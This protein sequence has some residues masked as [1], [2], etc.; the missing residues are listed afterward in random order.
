LLGRRAE[1][2]GFEPLL[3]KRPEYVVMAICLGMQSLNVALGGNLIQ[4]I[5]SQVYRIKTLEQGIKA[6][7]DTI[8]R[9]FEAF[10][11]PGPGVGGAHMHGLRLV[12][13]SKFASAFR[14]FNGAKVVSVH[15]QGVAKV[16][17][18][19]KV[20]ATSLDGK[21][22]EGLYHTQY[23]NVFGVQFHPEKRHLWNHKA[24][25]R[26]RAGTRDD[27]HLA[28]AFVKDELSQRFHRRLWL[29]VSNM[30][31]GCAQKR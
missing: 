24:I 16:G 28:T 10:L 8:H 12:G 7:S 1:A 6:K 26:A 20:W 13:K 15:H 22:I 14:K 3:K 27:N 11:L 5:P 4:D 17:S 31:T 25:Y 30:I 29:F 23:P 21:I 2:N 18:G 19:L 9:S